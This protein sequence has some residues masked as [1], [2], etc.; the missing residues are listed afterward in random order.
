MA[1]RNT[2]VVDP[3]YVSQAW[4]DLRIQ[5]IRKDGWRCTECGC[6]CRGR[7]FDESSPHV[8]HIKTRRANPELALDM[9]NLRTLCGPCHSRRTRLDESG[10]PLIGVDGYPIEES[11][12]AP[13]RYRDH[14]K[15][16]GVNSND[17]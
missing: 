6:L 15:T 5:R 14:F 10:K 1:R 3:F 9:N 2:K 4:R 13:A 12:D 11:P 8:D 16:N 7:R 17:R